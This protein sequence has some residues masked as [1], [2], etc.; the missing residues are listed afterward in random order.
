[1]G[2]LER[3]WTAA[4]VGWQ[5]A[6]RTFQDPSQV[7]K[8]HFECLRDEYAQRWSRYSNS[9]FDKASSYN[10]ERYKQNYRLYRN[11]RS[12][13][14]PCK[15]LVEFYVANIYPG[16]ISK[17]GLPFPD[18][19]PS[20]IPF[21]DDTN[22]DL[23]AAIAQIWQWSNWQALKSRQIRFCAALGDVLSEVIDDTEKRKV[24]L[25]IIWPGHVA[26]LE[27]DHCGNV[28]QYALEYPVIQEN[29]RYIYRKEVDKETFRYYKD[30]REFDYGFG[31]VTSNIYGFVPATWTKH[32]DIGGEHGDP[33]IAGSEPLFDE[34]NG[35]LCMTIDQVERIL[36]A[37]SVLW[38]QASP[39]MNPQKRGSTSEF[40]DQQNDQETHTFMTG[41]P[42]G[43]VDSLIAPLDFAGVDI[44]AGRLITA[45]EDNHPE[46]T[47]YRK[48][49]EMSQITGPAAARL[50]GD[51][52][53]RVQDAQANYDQ[54][55]IS[56]WRM[57][58]AIAGERARS[59][60]WGP[61]SEQQK[62]FVP[63][64]LTS[65]ERG[66]LDMSIATRP[67]LIP[68][69]L[70]MAMETQATWAG[71]KTA[72]EAGVPLE[73]ALKKEGWTEDELTE[74]EV[75]RDKEAREQE[76]S[77]QRDQLLSQEDV[78]DEDIEQ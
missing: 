45:I 29:E 12:L 16:R 24:Y 42:G 30:G 46:L 33:A 27:L 57:A 4:T 19:T 60:A 40:T 7:Y 61:L 8:Q 69:K 75:A 65:Y 10:W 63:F 13:Q 36:R 38:G 76:E 64:D 59:G 21:S 14:N 51:V 3:M 47:L 73:L 22:E 15:Q 50:I 43:R 9:L 26:D 67:L 18:G 25:D 28:E 68:T 53:S 77:I 34:L 74:L 56:L 54:T 41:A 6:L 32:L 39:P 35:L 55:N 52:S 31:T 48:L 1:M 72:T 70:E 78:V 37:P 66:D 5:A 20:A 49:R 11:I 62:K 58:T 17:N 2:V 23:I 44:S 71:V